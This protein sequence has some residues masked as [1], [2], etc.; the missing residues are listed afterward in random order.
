MERR[1]RSIDY[2]FLL[3]VIGLGVAIYLAIRF[4]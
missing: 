3:A 4:L 1:F 2:R